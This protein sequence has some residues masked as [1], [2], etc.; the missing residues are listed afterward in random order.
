MSKLFHIGDLHIGH[1]NILKYRSE[2]GSIQEHDETIIN[3]ITSTVS[4]RDTLYLHGDCFFS[5]DSLNFL[6]ELR[7]IGS[8]NWILGNHDSDKTERQRVIHTAM[9][10]GLIDKVH[11]IVKVHGFWLS[12]AP[13]HPV[14]LR[15]HKNIHGHVHGNTIP[16]AR[17]FNVSCENI[18]YR[19]VSFQDVKAASNTGEV[20]TRAV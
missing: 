16:D 20:F 11:G 9:T 8:I 1:R 10:E 5:A 17:Y 13:I 3:G 6:R 2:F 14:E 15:G 18:G 19:P 7:Y 12:H 4:K